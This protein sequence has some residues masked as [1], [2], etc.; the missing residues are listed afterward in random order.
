MLVEQTNGAWQIVGVL[1][2][3]RSIH[4]RRVRGVSAGI[5]KMLPLILASEGVQ[6]EVLSLFH[7]LFL[8]DKSPQQ[9]ALNLVEC[10]A[11]I[12]LSDHAALSMV[13]HRLV[14]DKPCRVPTAVFDSLRK[15]ACYRLPEEQ[16]RNAAAQESLVRR[17]RYSLCLLAMGAEVRCGRIVMI[18][19][20]MGCQAECSYIP[21][22]KFVASV[23][24]QSSEST[25]SDMFWC[26]VLN[27]HGG[28]FCTLCE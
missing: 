3:F 15:F 17:Q 28:A 1:H 22:Q 18:D 13:M 8:K 26:L 4:S 2:F 7:F 9:A 10:C 14:E 12:T 24:L 19:F 6:K 27:L 21:Y 23:L 25:L 11:G 16:R 20:W 5:R